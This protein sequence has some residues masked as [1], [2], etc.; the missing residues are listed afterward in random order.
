MLEVIH[1]FKR[2]RSSRSSADTEDH[3]CSH[4]ESL[5]IRNLLKYGADLRRNSISSVQALGDVKSHKR[6]CELCSLCLEGADAV[7]ESK[8]ESYVDKKM[9]SIRITSHAKH[10]LKVSVSG[11]YRLP[12]DLT[13]RKGNEYTHE[14]FI[15]HFYLQEMPP[16]LM[17]DLET[18]QLIDERPI[19][20]EEVKRWLETCHHDHGTDCGSASKY[21]FVRRPKRLL[22]ID[23]KENNLVELPDGVQYAALSYVWGGVQLVHLNAQNKRHL[24]K[25]GGLL[26]PEYKDL[27]PATIWDAIDVTKAIDVP[28]LWID[29][30]C[31]PQDDPIETR[32]Q[33]STMQN[34]FGSAY[35]TIIAGQGIS[36]STGLFG[37]PFRPR[38]VRY[39]LKMVDDSHGEPVSR[40]VGAGLTLA[41]IA[42]NKDGPDQ[43]DITKADTAL[44]TITEIEQTK[45]NSRAWTYQEAQL[46]SRAL[47]FLDNQVFWH[48][49]KSTWCERLLGRKVN[50]RAHALDARYCR[51]ENLTSNPHFRNTWEQHD[52]HIEVRRDGRTVTVASEA[53]LLYKDLVTAYT[54]RDIGNINDKLSAFDG[55]GKVLERCLDSQLLSGLPESLLDLALLWHPKNKLTKVKGPGFPSWSWAGWQG[56]VEFCEQHG[57]SKGARRE[58]HDDESRPERVRP[59]NRWYKATEEGWFEPVNEY[60]CGIKEAIQEDGNLP[61]GWSG[62]LAESTERNIDIED[63]PTSPGQLRT[64]TMMSSLKVRNGE[65]FNKNHQVIGEF[66]FDEEHDNVQMFHDSP[67]HRRFTFITLSETQ[68]FRNEEMNTA[69][70]GNLYKHPHEYYL[71]NIMAVEEAGDGATLYRRGIGKVFQDEW[72]KA[73]PEYKW[74]N[75][76]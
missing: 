62:F 67:S 50:N 3:L 40:F 51:L 66:A 24:M 54:P 68:F 69:L 35:C 16:S 70:R 46:S 1:N 74:V 59:L 9:T 31:I 32:H 25:K 55:I 29:S 61:K 76:G 6:T 48:C 38:Q 73:R 39:G 23:V 37:T 8:Q 17:T 14:D 33:I 71:Y 44:P 10:Q 65:V 72:E 45:W 64:Y 56:A 53:F 19:D 30:L 2:R 11:T 18:G 5:D 63:R 49:N 27:V 75:L 20:F 43:W 13:R 47:V 7:M 58:L 60:G 36:A 26:R 42:L 28:Y 34:I 22:V 12:L 21:S 57:V 52:S 15:E 41:L 4:C